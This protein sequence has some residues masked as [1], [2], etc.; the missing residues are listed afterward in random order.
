MQPLQYL[1]KHVSAAGR[2]QECV[3]P[4]RSLADAQDRAARLLGEGLACTCICITRMTAA[5][6]RAYGV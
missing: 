4:A 1:I 5:Q 2:R 6:R 3:L